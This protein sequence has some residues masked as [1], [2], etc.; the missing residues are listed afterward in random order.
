MARQ[1]QEGV[2]LPFIPSRLAH[3]ANLNGALAMPP[4]VLR[5]PENLF[6][7]RASSGSFFC[8][9]LVYSFCLSFS[10][11]V[12]FFLIDLHTFLVR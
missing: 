10:W 12:Y 4:L 8:Q 5:E 9:L 3:H 7:L 11:A 1:Q 6:C 2:L